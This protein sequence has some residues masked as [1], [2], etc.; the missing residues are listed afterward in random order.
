MVAAAETA[1]GDTRPGSGAGAQIGMGLG[2]LAM[3]A[4]LLI[5]LPPVV[6][7]I[8]I[9][10]NLSLALLIL[11]VTLYLRHPL[12]ISS[13]PTI[14]LMTTMLRLSL[15]IASTR[16]I[17]LNGDQGAQAAGHVIEA[18]GDFVVGGSY[19]VGF[20]VFALF[21]IINFV[22]I[23]KGSG[24]IA[25]VAARFTLD[26]MP[27]K[28][29]AI[30]ADLNNGTIDDAEGK[31]RRS[32]LQREADFY[33]SM[34]GASKFVRGDAI[35]GILIT[36]V[37]LLGGL[38]IGTLQQ[39]M[40]LSDAAQTY[41]LLTVGDGLVSAIP[42]LLISL[43][44]GIIVTRAGHDEELSTQLSRQLWGKPRPLYISASVLAVLALVP[45]LP[46]LAFG[47]LAIGLGLAGRR[48]A[49]EGD[50][51]QEAKTTRAVPAATPERPADLLQP[52]D[53]LELQVGYGLIDLVDPDKDGELIER[54]RAL[55][56]EYT[57]QMGFPVP[58][59]HIRDNL[60]LGSEEYAILVRGVR[61]ASGQ[62]FADQSLAIAPPTGSA[63]LP[64]TETKDPTF[65]LP[66]FWIRPEAKE[67][68]QTAGYTVVDPSS[69][70]VTHLTEVIR[71]HSS[72]LLG[73]QQVQEMLDSVSATQPK[74]VAEIVPD[75]LPLGAVQKVLQRLLRESV[76]VRDL[77]TILE[78][79]ADYSSKTKDPELLTELVRER[80][81]AQISAQLAP[82]GHLGVLVLS[83][84]VEQLISGSLERTE[85][86][87][88]V[89][90]DAG[91]IARITQGVR[92]AVE[93]VR[94]LHPDPTILC[95]PEIRPQ[96]R[97]MIE[98]VLPRT[99]VISANELTPEMQVESIGTVMLSP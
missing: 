28:Q 32:A 76:P 51:A 68:A 18:F 98:R 53:A 78:G 46:H 1:L 65:G 29:M 58:L 40:G 48:T 87:T 90:L 30:D 88:L 82:D 43:A 42:A 81:A 99:A 54:I 79:L 52:P 17:L 3:L 14:L 92:E 66:G 4:V 64:G 61:A 89:N 31:R 83:G 11:L 23:T 27:G 97:R 85:H 47:L 9:A 69:V 5:T 41:F 75:A 25:E 45:G 93:Q 57:Q 7:D 71:S 38:A 39:G 95:S 60:R 16:L 86:G 72:E 70:V 37:N 59:I 84:E 94:V 91:G 36:F 12:E 34:D 44:A 26:A 96:L 67:Q 33:G 62:V 2:V 77:P 10:A 35:A 49:L 50:R 6:L 19:A 21:V 73:R 20:V 55:R 24:R 8:G 15:N 63:P 80:L 22:V 13:F 56:R 74:L